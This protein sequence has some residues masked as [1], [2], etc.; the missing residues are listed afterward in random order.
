MS[1][2]NDIS[3]IPPAA[4]IATGLNIKH[5][6]HITKIEKFE[7]FLK[8]SINLL[9]DRSLDSYLVIVVGQALKGC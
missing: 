7:K 4:L 3:L 2:C 9:D 5:D 6:K 8:Q 1:V